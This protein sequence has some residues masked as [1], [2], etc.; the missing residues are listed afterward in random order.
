MRR[1]FYGH[2][3]SAKRKSVPNLHTRQTAENNIFGGKWSTPDL[4]LGAR[5]TKRV[6]GKQINVL[7]AQGVFAQ[8]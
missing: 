3:L 5:L 6:A 8:Y 1:S 2:F 4:C 7:I